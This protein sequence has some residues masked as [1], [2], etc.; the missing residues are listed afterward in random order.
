MGESFT[1]KILRRQIY[2]PTL[3][4]RQEELNQI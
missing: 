4:Y 2:A 3:K 1:C